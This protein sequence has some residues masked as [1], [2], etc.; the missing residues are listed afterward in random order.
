[1]PKK[2]DDK[3]QNSLPEQYSERSQNF[4]EMEIEVENEEKNRNINQEEDKIPDLNGIEDETITDKNGS[5]YI[6]KEFNKGFIP[7]NDKAEII[8]SI[9]LKFILAKKKHAE[10][11]ISIKGPQ[12]VYIINRLWYKKWKEYSR[13]D[14]MKRVIKTYFTYINRPIKFI[15]ND[16]KFPGII[17]NKDLLIRNKTDD[18][19]RKILVSKH[20]D[21]LD[22][23]LIYKKHYKFLS[24]ERFDLLNDY[25]KCD[26]IL[27]AQKIKG[28]NDNKNYD[29]FTAHIRIIFLPILS[30][31]KCVNDENIDNFIK[32]QNIIYDMYFK[33]NNKKREFNNELFNILLENPQILTNMG[34]EIILPNDRDELYNHIKNFKFYIP[35]DNNTKTLKEMIDFIFCKETIEL[36]KKDEKIEEKDIG[37]NQQVY[38][39]G[40]SDVFHLNWFHNKE[41]LDEIKNGVIFVEYIPFQDCESQKLASIFKVKEENMEINEISVHRHKIPE[42]L[43]GH[44]LH[45]NDCSEDRYNLDKYSLSKEENKNGL[46]GLNNLGNTCYMS[47]GLQC[48][49]NCELLTKYFL[50]ESYKEF[51]NKENPI[52]SKGEIVEKYSQLIH[53]IWYGN[54]DCLNP[55]LFKEAFGKMFPAFKD[56]RQQDAIEFI[57]YLIDSL[58]EDLNKVKSKPYIETKELSQDLSEDEHFKIKNDLY[59]CRNQS[60]IVDLIYGFYKSTLFCPNENCKNI[61]KSFEPFNIITLSLVNESQLRK[62]EECQIEK[63]KNLGKKTINV[64]F[65]PFKISQKALKFTVKIKKEMDIFEF[66]KKIEIMTGF[67]KNSFE[68]YKMHCSEF[69]P[70]KP[71]I[72]LLDDFLK[73]EN[74]VYLLQV[75]PY[76]FG[77]PSDYFDSI[78]EELIN[79]Q[80]KLYLEEEKYEGNDLYN[81]YIK[82]QKKC[83]TDDD[84][85]K[86]GIYLNIEIS[87][88][89]L[90]RI[91]E[92]EDIEMKDSNLHIDKN[93]WIKAEFYN[94]TYSNSE[95]NKNKGISYEEYKMNNSRIIYLNREWDNSQVYICILE[96][97][98]GTRDDLDEIKAE[99]F[100]DIKEIT[101]K[102]GSMDNKKKEVNNCKYLE[103]ITN[104]PLFLK[105][106]KVF[107]FN[108]TNAMEK[109]EGWKNYIFPFD[110]GK[111]TIKSILKKALENNEIVD[112]E[113]LFKIIWKPIFAQEYNERTLPLEIKKSERLMEIFRA[114]RE[115]KILNKNNYEEGIGGKNKKIK[116]IHLEELLK[117]FNEIEKL[118]NDNQWYCPKCK[119]F[120]LASKKMEIYSVNHIIIIHLKRFRNNRKIENFVEF[121]IEGLNLNKFLQNKNEDLI[122][123]LF[124]VANHIGGLHGGHYFAYCKNF[125]DKKWYEFNDSH[126]NKI[127]KK[128]VVSD[129]AYVLFYNRRTEAM[130]NEEDLFKKPFIEIDLT[131]YSK[132]MK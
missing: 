113:L 79:W 120:Q 88:G 74:K 35:N 130:N 119:L 6:P 125:I 129:N 27:K 30:L 95:E 40:I 90:N 16:T 61:S 126:V 33:Q 100:K 66:K 107:N 58:H 29:A 93:K 53:H 68:I 65:I 111:H 67:N 86:N 110:S 127:E 44:C 36:I 32:S 76:V 84:L 101:K 121:P 43:H 52:G 75:P 9:T 26:Y 63:D 1:M 60:F 22:S 38:I 56:Y 77:K 69:I 118:S 106:L 45:C 50:S 112:I 109:G 116:K 54:E 82:K 37:L 21:C 8:K 122:Y 48:L 98:E 103:E 104:H 10:R 49:S 59:L 72:L 25:F 46:V 24:K 3:S 51:I 96:M 132:N 87:E 31:F 42:N 4:S 97:L 108:K 117:N 14:T 99:W 114:R 62:L 23:K 70:I 12:E 19:D 91:I 18:K 17:N 124:A 13:H 81:E 83:K 41:N 39:H 102:L 47:T 55:K 11:H 131:K 57:S 105:Y 78:Y 28:E 115:D 15:P 94:C 2:S 34:V 64:T 89:N 20:N 128:K 5:T 73:G 85:V 92:K 7:Q 123:D 71:N 80:D